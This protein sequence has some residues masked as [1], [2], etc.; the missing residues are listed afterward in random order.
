M[1]NEAKANAMT[2]LIYIYI[3]LVVDYRHLLYELQCLS[4]SRPT[5]PNNPLPLATN[6]IQFIQGGAASV[7]SSDDSSLFS[8]LSTRVGGGR[9]QLA[10]T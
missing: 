2:T 5:S 3:A 1:Q 8:S 9:V 10:H 7:S 4:R 6:A